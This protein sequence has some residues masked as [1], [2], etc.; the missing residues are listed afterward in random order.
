VAE[1]DIIGIDPYMGNALIF[2]SLFHLQTNQI[3]TG[4][5]NA[6]KKCYKS[7]KIIKILKPEGRLMKTFK[8][9]QIIIGC[10]IIAISLISSCKEKTSKVIVTEHEFSIEKVGNRNEYTIVAKGKV[11]NVGEADVKNVVVTGFS[12]SCTSGFSPGIWMSSE[13]EKTPEEKCT[14]NFIPAGNEADFYFRDVAFMYAEA[15]KEPKEM[16]ENMEVV[17][18]SFEV[19]N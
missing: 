4:L 15:N 1:T 13:R 5:Q 12:K 17:V 7:R 18:D 11:K 2:P 14:I 3:N 19:A 9:P 8:Y 6:F 16:P 10:L